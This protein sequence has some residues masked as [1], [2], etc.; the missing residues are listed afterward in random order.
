M[1]LGARPLGHETA[2]NCGSGARAECHG[3]RALAVNNRRYTREAF[4]CH[5]CKAFTLRNGRVQARGVIGQTRHSRLTHELSP[6]EQDITG[7]AVLKMKDAA[8]S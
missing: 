4:G 6:P 7:F 2:Q 3:A 8:C 5:A 1:P